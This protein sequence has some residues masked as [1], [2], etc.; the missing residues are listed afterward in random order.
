MNVD[1][2]PIEGAGYSKHIL[3]Y[4]VPEARRTT[5]YIRNG[6]FDVRTWGHRYTQYKGMNLRRVVPE[7]MLSQEL[8]IA[9]TSKKVAKNV[10]MFKTVL[11]EN[12]INGNETVEDCVTYNHYVV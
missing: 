10:G 6:F 12:L 9:K 8:E 5:P 1:T 11:Y 7:N 3:K 2:F 4:A